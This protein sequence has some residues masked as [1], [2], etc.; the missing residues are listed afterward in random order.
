VRSRRDMVLRSGLLRRRGS[1]EAERRRRISSR[2]SDESGQMRT[3]VPG[4][5]T[6]LL[7]T[8]T[9]V[10]TADVTRNPNG[11]VVGESLW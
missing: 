10:S 4:I 3:S 7:A 1:S 6:L 9:A 5:I 2:N 8:A 11:S